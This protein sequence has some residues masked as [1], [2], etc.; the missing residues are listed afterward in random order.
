[1]DDKK[2]V[3]SLGEEGQES[4]SG[5]AP[6]REHNFYPLEE[7]SFFGG[8]PK[9]IHIFES[10]AAFSGGAPQREHI[11]ERQGWPKKVLPQMT[12]RHCRGFPDP[13][14]KQLQSI[15]SYFPGCVGVAYAPPFLM[16]TWE[17]LPNAPWPVI[18]GV[19]GIPVYFGIQNDVHPP[20]FG[21][22]GRSTPLM[23]TAAEKLLPMEQ[24]AISKIKH[25]AESLQEEGIRLK[26]FGWMGMKWYA[27]VMS[28]EDGYKLPSQICG[29]VVVWEI[30]TPD[31]IH[32]CARRSIKPIIYGD[33]N[34]SIIDGSCYSP[35][36]RPGMLL[37]SADGAATTSGVPLL[38][39]NG[40]LFFTVAAHGFEG[41]HNFVYHPFHEDGERGIIGNVH[42]RMIIS[43]VGF[44]RLAPGMKYSCDLFERDEDGQTSGVTELKLTGL[45]HHDAVGIF[46]PLT[47][48]SPYNGHCDGVLLAKG[49]MLGVGIEERASY[50]RSDITYF[51]NGG[52]E[53]LDGSCGCPIYTEDL[54]VV[55]FIRY[56]DA[57]NRIAFSPSVDHLIDNGYKLQEIF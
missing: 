51:A 31:L 18:L 16:V 45:V 21:P 43:D 39:P 22:T 15:G 30:S 48:D 2:I 26:Y 28:E 23:K 20:G 29:L 13:T 4:F 33:S 47:M 40:D 38:A 25:I 11:P 41:N 42:S 24:P 32:E 57:A 17:I 53:I 36:L 52:K 1:M 54:E 49:F 3:I 35:N 5:A 44:V 9:R 12:V 46:T 10:L 55:G 19:D 37:Q 27:Q 56:Y 34:R 8:D 14:T 50:V 6:H 7:F